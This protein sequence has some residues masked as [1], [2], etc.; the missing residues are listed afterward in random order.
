MNGAATSAAPIEISTVVA[1]GSSPFL[2]AAFQ[3]AWQAAAN[4]TAAKTNGSIGP[5]DHRPAC[6]GDVRLIGSDA[7]LARP[8]PRLRGEVERAARQTFIP[9]VDVTGISAELPAN[10]GTP[11]PATAWVPCAGI[12]AGARRR[13]RGRARRASPNGD[14]G[15]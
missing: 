9:R 3:P 7:P 13:H 15:A 14:C 5:L 12:A 8:L 1:S 11:R 10:Q 4:S 2:I 6:A